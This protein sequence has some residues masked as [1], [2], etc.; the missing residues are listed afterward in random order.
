MGHKILVLT[1]D[2]RVPGGVSNYYEALGLHSNDGVDYFFVSNDKKEYLG[3]FFWRL[4]KNYYLFINILI[5]KD[6]NL[7]HINPSLN[8]K[9]YLRD[10]LFLMIAHFF[11]KK[12]LVFFHGWSDEFENK[13]QKR[14]IYKL[15][16][17]KSF[18]RCKHII[19][20]SDYFKEKL[21]SLGCDP[22]KTKFWIE[23]TVA[24]TSFLEGFSIEDKLI[25]YRKSDKIKV[26]FLS[27]IVKEKGVFIALEAFESLQKEI[28]D[29]QLELIIAGDG[30][31][32]EEAKEMVK[33]RNISNVT[34]TG[35]IK[36][37]KKKKILH[38]AH[39]FL[40]PTYYGEGMPTNILEAMLYGMPIVSRYNAG[41][42]DAVNHGDNGLLTDSK[43][44]EEFAEMLMSYLS[45]GDHYDKTVRL[46]HKKALENFSSEIVKQ[47]ILNIYNNIT[48]EG[49]T[50][51]ISV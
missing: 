20:L 1:P 50:K 17:S 28:K 46:N 32:L 7:V 31:A 48:T 38:D 26:L 33:T 21:I 10:S 6:I 27:R 4:I 51:N 47:R 3:S 37:D 13:I 30:S 40:F 25:D 14:Y 41:I 29:K 16:F 11:N 34:F 22:K 5:K 12:T 8:F 18:G 24:D 23:S 19:V 2:L 39:I 44:S 9:S 45:D 43:D 36:G 35:Y 49:R 42:A 15:I